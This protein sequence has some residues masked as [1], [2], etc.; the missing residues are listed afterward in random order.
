MTETKHFCDKC[1]ELITADRT[2]LAVKSGPRRPRQPEIEL[3]S[4]CLAEF[5]G[6]LDAR[7]DGTTAPTPR[8]SLHN[9]VTAGA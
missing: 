5:T 4:D 8:M 7:A 3:C 9:R 1:D 2:L 6:W